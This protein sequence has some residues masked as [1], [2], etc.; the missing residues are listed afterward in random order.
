M[1]ERDETV[2]RLLAH[3]SNRDAPDT[4]MFARLIGAKIASNEMLHLGLARD[5]LGALLKRHFPDAPALRPA[6][7]PI[8]LREHQAFVDALHAMLL[9]EESSLD[10]TDPDARCLAAIIAA[11]CLR[12]DHLWRDLGLNGRDDVTAILTRHYPRLVARNTDNTR[13]KKFLARELA[14]SEGRVPE[15]A[16][17][18]PG[19]EDYG[20]CYP[21][22]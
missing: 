11:A 9:R 13:W 18:C 20:F 21:A 4:E 12:P 7:G 14:Y 10:A 15:P 17:G 3:A 22:K 8:A 6:S 5:A 1:T 2:A 16:P 19:C